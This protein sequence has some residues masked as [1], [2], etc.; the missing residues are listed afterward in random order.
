MATLRPVGPSTRLTV[1][2]RTI[3]LAQ[4]DSSHR[5]QVVLS[6]TKNSRFPAR[7]K[8]LKDSSSITD[9]SSTNCYTHEVPFSSLDS[10]TISSHRQ[11]RVQC[12]A[13]RVLAVI[14]CLPHLFPVSC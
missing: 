6:L 12:R 8:L 13:S 1:R 4:D 3:K 14:S 5:L 7:D 2:K 9:R 11:V 10:S